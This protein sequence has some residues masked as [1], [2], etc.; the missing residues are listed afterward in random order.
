VT[1]QRNV[2]TI[3]VALLDEGVDAWRPVQ[4]E[5]V[6]GDLY[7]LVGKPPD[8][9]VWP[10][11]TGDVVRCEMRTLSGG[12]GQG[13]PVLVVCEKS[14]DSSSNPV[15]VCYCAEGWIC[16]A[17]RELPWPHDDCAGP[18]V[19]CPRCTPKGGGRRTSKDWR[20]IASTLRW[21]E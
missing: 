6:G 3:Y 21:S 20:S 15:Q 12:G 14:T 8:D 10:F 16:E 9:E 4:A 13:E 2:A 7:R 19:R 1:V 5:H 18:G 11:A 17:H